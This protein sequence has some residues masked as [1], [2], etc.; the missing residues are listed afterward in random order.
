LATPPGTASGAA[1]R[2][3]EAQPATRKAK[4]R[5]RAGRKRID[6]ASSLEEN[7]EESDVLP[8]GAKKA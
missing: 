7:R 8:S 4:S 5:A 2:F 3:E 1:A 6:E